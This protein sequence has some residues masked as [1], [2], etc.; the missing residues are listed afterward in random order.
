MKKLITGLLLVVIVLFFAEISFSLDEEPVIGWDG[1]PVPETMTKSKTG[2]NLSS[3]DAKEV[4]QA[5]KTLKGL[6]Y[7]PGPLDGLW[8]EA[9]KKSIKKFQ[10]ETQL[11][12]TGNLDE[13][14]KKR[15]G[16]KEIGENT[17][18]VFRSQKMDR[19]PWKGHLGAIRMQYDI[20]APLDTDDQEVKSILKRAIEELVRKS[21]VDA[22]SVRLYLEETGDLPYAIAEWAPYGDWEKAEKGKPKSIFKTK[23]KIY[24]E[25]RPPKDSDKK[26][27]L[28]LEKRQQIFREV[29]R[30]QDTTLRMAKKKFPN[31]A[32]KKWDYAEELDKKFEKRICD[33]YGITEGQKSSIL[34]EGVMK[35]WLTDESPP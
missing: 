22:L 8:G 26:Y 1:K 2:K 31:D 23:I 12:V 18:K 32:I 7:D 33:K 19:S 16:I 10:Q 35:N 34:A 6:G 13:L 25:H 5:Q 29:Y 15:L 30:S 20:K 27:G 21:E 11:P 28:S 3:P 14:T 24:P 9:T 4:Y 17:Y